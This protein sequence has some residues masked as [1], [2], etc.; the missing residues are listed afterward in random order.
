MLFEGSNSICL[1]FI[2]FWMLQ[3]VLGNILTCLIRRRLVAEE[4]VDGG[5]PKGKGGVASKC[6]LCSACTETY[7][8][9]R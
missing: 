7:L 5:L 1:H 9:N 2:P 6:C 8:V 3:G 4:H